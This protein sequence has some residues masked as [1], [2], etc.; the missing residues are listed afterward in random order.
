MCIVNADHVPV[1]CL[2]L[3]GPKANEAPPVREVRLRLEN[4]MN[5]RG[6]CTSV[7][8]LDVANGCCSMSCARGTGRR[9]RACPA[10]SLVCADSPELLGP[11]LPSP[12]LPSLPSP[13][14]P[15]RILFV[16]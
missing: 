7:A 10:V 11:A 15:G 16:F 12:L 3:Q 14:F 5:L 9:R 4:Q 13:S 1:P 2:G 8:L 6:Q